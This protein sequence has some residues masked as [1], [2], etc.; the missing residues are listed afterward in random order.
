MRVTKHGVMTMIRHKLTMLPLLLLT[1]LFCPLQAVYT[2]IYN[3]TKSDIEC[4]WSDKDGGGY[5][6][7]VDGRPAIDSLT[8]NSLIKRFPAD[9]AVKLCEGIALLNEPVARIVFEECTKCDCR[10][11]GPY[12]LHVNFEY[13]SGDV[14]DDFTYHLR[15]GERYAD[16]Q[17]FVGFEH[18]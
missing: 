8:W 15:N 7:T 1:T 11:I 18:K 6:V 12:D 14:M 4:Y 13:N 17:I 10:N 9:S 5:H 3:S 16:G 2:E